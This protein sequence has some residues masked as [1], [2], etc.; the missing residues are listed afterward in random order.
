MTS[1]LLSSLQYSNVAAFLEDMNT[2]FTNAQ[3]FNEETSLVHH[4]SVTL[5]CLTSH[6]LK[7]LWKEKAPPT[8]EELDELLAIMTSARVS[9]R[10]SFFCVCMV[11]V[12]VC[13]C[14][15]VRVCVS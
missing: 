7:E 12:C 13:V 3:L 1:S 5:S 8:G 14:H 2:L 9:S 4:D 6:T 11:C 15:C 10:L